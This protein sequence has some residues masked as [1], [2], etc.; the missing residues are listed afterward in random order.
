MNRV[1]HLVDRRVY[2]F[3]PRYS[4]TRGFAEGELAMPD[5]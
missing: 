4:H 3:S 1:A 5:R 2:H